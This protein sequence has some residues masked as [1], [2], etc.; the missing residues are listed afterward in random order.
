[1]PGKRSPPNKVDCHRFSTHISLKER[2]N[3]AHKYAHSE[4]LFQQP[5]FPTTLPHHRVKK[6]RMDGTYSRLPR[7]TCFGTPPSEVVKHG[8]MH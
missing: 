3:E 5:R 4:A 7:K 2:I 8:G 6:T 1:M